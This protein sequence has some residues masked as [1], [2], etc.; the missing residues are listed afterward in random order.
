MNNNRGLKNI[1]WVVG[2]AMIAQTIVATTSAVNDAT[3][4]EIDSSMIEREESEIPFSEMI[5]P[6]TESDY[7]KPFILTRA[8][9]DSIVLRWATNSYVDWL[10]LRTK[11]VTISRLTRTKEGLRMDCLLYTSPSPRDS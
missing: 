9:G 1:I 3:I 7:P 2:A 11:G 4:P 5:V 10:Y 6:E 8:Y